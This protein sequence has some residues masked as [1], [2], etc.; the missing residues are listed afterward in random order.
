MAETLKKISDDLAQTVE[1]A[2]PSVVRVSA[3]RR[4][5]ATGIVWSSDGTIVT[6]H[7][8]VERDDNIEVGLPNGET[9]A[10][11]LAGRDPSTDVA[12]LRTSAEGLAEPRWKDAADLRV[13][14]IVLALGRPGAS[15]LATMGIV[16]ALEQSWRTQAGGRMGNYLQTDVVMY[17][18]FSGGPLVD[19][20]GSVV[21]LNTS[22]LARGAAVAVPTDD[23]QRVVSALL[24]AGRIR[25]G[26][27]GVGAQ[28]A[29]LPEGMAK[30]LGQESGL[31]LVSVEAGGPADSSGLVM[32][33][34]L[35]A[36]NGNPVRH[37]DD[38][39]AAL[40]EEAIGDAVPAKL[41]RG[42]V[43]KDTTVT[44]GERS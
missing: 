24:A 34:T 36:L 15:V 21:G 5:P 30:E 19:S 11:T 20:E 1:D 39:L 17:P 38:L 10:A 26:Y 42:G 31:L 12:V 6:A 27:L 43:L 41:I 22:A 8:V 40:G 7:H 44:V 25:R 23:L 37:L 14:N 2:G 35:V 4:L 28:P 29:R 3:R 33:D 13:G 32:G 9:V 18:G 16:S